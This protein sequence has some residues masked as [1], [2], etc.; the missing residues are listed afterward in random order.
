MTEIRASDADRERVARFL[1]RHFADGRLTVDELSERLESAFAAR[2][3]PELERLGR[4]LPG[5]TLGRRERRAQR[6]A[7]ARPRLVAAATVTWAVLQ[8]VVLLVGALLMATCA[9]TMFVIGAVMR[10]GCARRAR[11]SRAYRVPSGAYRS[12]RLL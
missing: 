11:S 5:R 9:V 8:A 2:T 10:G 4:D 3:L 1:N 12:P 7:T 6:T